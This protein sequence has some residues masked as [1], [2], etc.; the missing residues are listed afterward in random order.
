MLVD[1]MDNKATICKH[2]DRKHAL[3][4]HIKR[5]PV[6]NIQT[7]RRRLHSIIKTNR[8]KLHVE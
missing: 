5:Q 4:K 1:L 6:K 3:N 2:I 7:Y 8:I